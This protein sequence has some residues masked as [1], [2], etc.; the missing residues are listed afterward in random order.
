MQ[1]V[2]GESVGMHTSGKLRLPFGKLTTQHVRIHRQYSAESLRNT[3]LNQRET[4]LCY[5][6]HLV[7]LS[8]LGKDFPRG[9]K[10]GAV[11]AADNRVQPSRGMLIPPLSQ[12]GLQ[13]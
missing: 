8:C 7:L 12:W 4:P 6:R 2:F 10:H 5:G 9:L 3:E 1:N 13:A 11:G